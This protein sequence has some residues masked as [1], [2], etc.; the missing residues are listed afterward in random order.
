M[1]RPVIAGLAAVCLLFTACGKVPVEAPDDLGELTQ[2]LYVNY[3]SE[4]GEELVAGL[5][6]LETYMLGLDLSAEVDDRAVTPPKLTDTHLADVA[7]PSSVDL[8]KQVPVA[9]SYLS[10]VS[11]A[12]HYELMLEPNQVCIASNGTKYHDRVFLTDTACF[13]DGSCEL[14][15]TT[16]EIRFENFLASV[17]LDEFQNYRNVMMEDGRTAVIQRSWMEQQFDSDN[18][19]SSWDLR[20]AISVRLPDADDDS[21]TLRFNSFWSS[22]TI[23]GVGDD[24]YAA[25]VK[26]GIEEGFLNEDAFIAGEAC[27][28][29]RDREYDRP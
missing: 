14:M 5:E 7:Y 12:D 10:D 2:Y 28:N 3:E 9:V 23:P 21:K 8:D 29:D 20:F 27:D 4:T 19:S 25:L 1:K 13:A 16:N 15:E 17:W 22:V 11:L 26:D 24:I 18:G 6:Q